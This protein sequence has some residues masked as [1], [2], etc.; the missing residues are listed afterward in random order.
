[1]TGQ[2]NLPLRL[3][4]SAS[5]DNFYPIGN[6]EVVEVVRSVTKRANAKPSLSSMARRAAESRTCYRR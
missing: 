4:D 2:L 5:F 1:M 6:E 3:S